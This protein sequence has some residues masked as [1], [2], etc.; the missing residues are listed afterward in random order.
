MSPVGSFI[1]SHEE[2]DADWIGAEEG[3]MVM[4]NVISLPEIQSMLRIEILN[5]IGSD[6]QIQQGDHLS[7]NWAAVALRST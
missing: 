6:Q 2:C 5:I 4:A 7:R 3:S 1:S